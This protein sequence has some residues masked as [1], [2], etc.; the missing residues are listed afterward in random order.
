MWE[1]GRPD[2]QKSPGAHGPAKK[3]G[4][5]PGEDRDGRVVSFKREWNIKAARTCFKVRAKSA[6]TVAARTC[7]PPKPL[8]GRALRGKSGQESRGECRTCHARL[9]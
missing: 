5:S 4:R 1:N 8:G 2:P 7:R 9:S 6:R 3:S